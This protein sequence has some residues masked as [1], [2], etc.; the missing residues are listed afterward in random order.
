MGLSGR[1]EKQRIA[2]DP[3]NLGW[4]GGRSSVHPFPKHIKIGHRRCTVRL[5]LSFKIWMGSI[6]GPWSYRGGADIALEGGAE[7]RHAWDWCGSA[8]RR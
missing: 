3:R 1:K 8:E 7:A 2:A 4:A 6:Q 5:D